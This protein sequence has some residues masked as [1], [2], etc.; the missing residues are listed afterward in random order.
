MSI[1][2]RPSLSPKWPKT[3]PPTGR[4]AKPTQKVA[5]A[6]NWAASGESFGEKNSGPKTKAAA[7]P[8]RKKSYHSM[9]VPIQLARATRTIDVL[10]LDSCMMTSCHGSHGRYSASTRH[11]LRHRVQ[12]LRWQWRQDT[13]RK[14]GCLSFPGPIGYSPSSLL[15]KE[16]FQGAR[17]RLSHPPY[18]LILNQ[19]P[20]TRGQ[21]QEYTG[22]QDCRTCRGKALSST[23]LDRLRKLVLPW[24]RF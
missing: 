18:T 1:F 12:N 21:S 17:P 9:E 7:V 14:R 4:A 15:W 6:A 24:H 23:R 8:Y 3:T 22:S 20:S 19:A 5:K 11:V 2:L 16:P 13:S 10:L